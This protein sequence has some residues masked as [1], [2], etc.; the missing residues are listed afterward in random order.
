MESEDNILSARV[1]L[2]RSKTWIQFGIG[3]AT[4][5]KVE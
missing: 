1:V 2:S 3:K 5:K 4:D